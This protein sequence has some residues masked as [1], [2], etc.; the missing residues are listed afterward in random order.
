MKTLFLVR[1]AKSSRDDRALPDRERPLGDRGR[2]D[3]PRQDVAKLAF[4]AREAQIRSGASEPGLAR[5]VPSS[6]SSPSQT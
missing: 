2:R 3:A 4:F 5:G 6:S 1:H